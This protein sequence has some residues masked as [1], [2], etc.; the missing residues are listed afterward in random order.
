GKVKEDG[1]TCTRKAPH[2]GRFFVLYSGHHLAVSLLKTAR[3]AL[4]ESSYIPKATAAV[5]ERSRSSPVS[6]GCLSTPLLAIP[7][8]LSLIETKRMSDKVFLDTNILIYS[9]SVSD[10]V[11]QLTARKLIIETASHIS[12][13]V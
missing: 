10:R 4:G 1:H 8:A 7:G 6:R 9:Y 13:Q 2:H 12:T 3:G 11:K 5:W